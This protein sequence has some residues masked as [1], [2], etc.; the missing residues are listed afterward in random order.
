LPIDYN[1][2]YPE[3]NNKEVCSTEG[4]LAY[5][6]LDDGVGNVE[7][8]G[9]EKIHFCPIAW[10][11]PQFEAIV[12]DCEGNTDAYP[13]KKMDTFSRIA[14]HEMTHMSTVG[15][16]IIADPEEGDDGQIKDV[17]LYDDEGDFPANG[18]INAHALADPEQGDYY[19]PE[20]TQNNADNYAWMALDALVSRHCASDPSG[21]SWQ[22]FFT[23]SPP[24]IGAVD[25]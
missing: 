3:E 16:P 22:D 17:Q 15:P 25:E 23:E 20:L 5:T 14:L 11:R 12:A 1:D 4:T 19:N 2:K 6:S 7:A 21:D 13:S 9:L 18:P 24:R 8:D 10:D